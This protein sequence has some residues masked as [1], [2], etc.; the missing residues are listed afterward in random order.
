MS[1]T[2]EFALPV[3]TYRFY[4]T[5][6]N[7]EFMAEVIEPA[8]ARSGH[9]ANWAS[10]VANLI[11]NTGWSVEAAI[12]GLLILAR[13]FEADEEGREQRTLQ[14]LGTVLG[15]ASAHPTLLAKPVTAAEFLRTAPFRAAGEGWTP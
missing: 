14:P 15:G 4:R 3:T 8:L 10:A 7:P 5:A 2:I 11:D 9:P 6:R 12:G 13:A 1:D